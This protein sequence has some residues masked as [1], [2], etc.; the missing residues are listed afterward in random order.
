MADIDIAFMSAGELAQRM[1]A[2]ELSAVEA[3]RAVLDRIDATQATLNAFITVSRD[4]AL[5]AAQAADDAA[6]RGGTLGGLHGVPV[7]VKDIINTAGIR[8]TWGSRTMA[9]NVPTADAVAVERLKQAG[10]VIVGKTTTPD[11]AHKL[12]TDAPLFGMTRNPWNL[13]ARRADRAAARRS[14]WPPD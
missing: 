1:R 7:S 8:T 3:T 4:E 10:A 11:F 6:A 9:D 12:L 13:D 14:P 5:R 2:R